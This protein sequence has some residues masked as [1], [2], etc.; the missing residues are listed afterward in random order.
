M[1]RFLSLIP[2]LAL[3]PW[4][5]FAVTLAVAV[6]GALVLHAAVYGALHRVRRV[7]PERLPLRG[8]LVQATERSARWA[9]VLMA[10]RAALPRLPDDAEV[11]AGPVATALSIALVVAVARLVVRAVGAVRQ[12]LGDRLDTGKADNLSERRILT[13]IGLFERL[14]NVVVVVVAVAVILLHFESV[15]RVGTGLLASAGIAGIVLGFAAQRVLGNLFAGIQIAI[16]QP[17]RVD[18]VVV[19]EGEWARVEEITLTY[20]VVR[21]WDLRRLVLPI[22]YFIE[23]PFQNWTRSSSQ[24]LGTVYVRTDYDVPVEAVRAEVGRLVEASEFFDGDLWRLHVTDLGERGVEM[25]A[26]MSAAT[27]DDVWELRCEVRE[28]ILRWLR[29]T[30]SEAL[31][32]TRV[33]FPDADGHLPA[34]GDGELAIRHAG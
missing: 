20:V 16:T 19:V 9:L 33:V 2:T 4:P 7:A 1:T 23:T 13:Q 3:D 6:G 25:R 28:G 22:S 24:V 10:A 5:A 29:E 27:A 34:G 14:L 31:P 17:I 30:H 21:I 11:V 32:R 15:R 12:S 26:L 8:L 18:D